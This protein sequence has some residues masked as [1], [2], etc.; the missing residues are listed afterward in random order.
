MIHVLTARLLPRILGALLLGCTLIGVSLSA[1]AQPDLQANPAPMQNP[2][3]SVL[4]LDDFLRMVLQESPEVRSI[5]LEDDRAAARVLE[6]R[7]LFDPTF[8]SGYEYKTQDEND[9]LNVLR[10]GLSVPFNLPFSPNLTMDYR[11]GL[12][13]SIDPS[14]ATSAFGETRVGLEVAP[15]VGWTTGKR[16]V[17]L[18]KVRLEP[19]RADARQSVRRNQLLLDATRAYLTW[20]EAQQVLTVNRELVDVAVERQTFISRR[21]RIG[22]EAAIDSVEAELIVVSREGAVAAATQKAEQAAA[23]L[24]VFLWNPD[25]SPMGFDFAAPDMPVEGASPVLRRDVPAEAEAMDRALRRRPELQEIDVKLQQTR[26][27]ERLARV[28]LRPD[29]KLE[30]QAVS[31]DDTPMDVADVKVGIKIDQSLFFRGDRSAVDEAEIEVRQTDL[32]RLLTERKIE[33]DV[34]SAVVGLREAQ[35]RAEAAER[36][37]QLA[38][39]LQRAEERR[40]DLGESTL[41]LL[42]QREQ[43]FAEARVERIKA[44]VAVRHARAD[45]QWATGAIADPYLTTLPGSP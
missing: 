18:E 8:A 40:F 23:K 25:G 20:V 17:K 35:R 4:S 24:A 32:E 38:R 42:N 41:F 44:R 3:S 19:R 27:D 16:G 21:A 11:R 31:Y 28:G 22:E 34:R 39:R 45:L 15:L 13:S 6:A 43:A 30:A 10:S 26:I 29:L 2:D 5:R 33:A 9:K 12:G 7:G 37:V 36:R 14:V 1:A